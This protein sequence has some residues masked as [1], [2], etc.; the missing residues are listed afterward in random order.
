MKLIEEKPHLLVFGE[1][2]TEISTNFGP[3]VIKESKKE[4]YLRL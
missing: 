3:P 1:K 4:N 2:E